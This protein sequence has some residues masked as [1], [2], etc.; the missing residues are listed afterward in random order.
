MYEGE[1]CRVGKG[2]DAK[3]LFR[4]NFHPH[5]HRGVVREDNERTVAGSMADRM[6]ELGPGGLFP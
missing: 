2:P 6:R 1:H 5:S 3:L 4:Y